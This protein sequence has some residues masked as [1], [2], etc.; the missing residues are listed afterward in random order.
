MFGLPTTEYQ[1]LQQI[2][3]ELNLLHKLYGLYNDVTVKING[4]FDI[5]WIDVNIEQINAELQDFQ[6]R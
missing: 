6:T 3:K 4:Y 5:T 2:R 1:E